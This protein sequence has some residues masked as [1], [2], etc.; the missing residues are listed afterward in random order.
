MGF[1]WK[2]WLIFRPA[3]LITIIISILFCLGWLGMADYKNTINYGETTCYI[4]DDSLYDIDT[5]SLLYYG[6]I[7][8]YAWIDGNLEKVVVKYPSILL[9]G[10]IKSLEAIEEWMNNFVNGTTCF[11]ERGVV[12]GH[13]NAVAEKPIPTFAIIAFSLTLA[14]ILTLSSLAVIYVYYK[15]NKVV[16]TDNM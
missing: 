14:W 8:C 2:K 11:V 16:R 10:G 6:K 3:V 1:A 13:N 15:T 4:T 5:Y 9:W 12:R 7:W